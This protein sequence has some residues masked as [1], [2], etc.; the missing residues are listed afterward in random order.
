MSRGMAGR[1]VVAGAGV[2]LIGVG[3]A[4]LALDA[5]RASPVGVAAWLAGALVL[6]DLVLVPLV[7]L[8][9]WVATR[10]A[11]RR[12]RVPVQVALVLLGALL[13]VGIPFALSPAR[14]S[15]SGTLLVQPYGWNLVLLAGGL[16]VGTAVAVVLVRRQSPYRRSEREGSG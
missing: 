14:G 6:D 5:D 4:Q 9:G 15:E 10:A 13:L 16:A 8:G 1:V 2:L 3:A 11:S 7:L 12:V